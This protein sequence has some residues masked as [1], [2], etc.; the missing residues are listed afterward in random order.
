M[1]IS[2]SKALKVKNRIANEIKDLQNIVAQNNSYIT[3]NEQP[4]DIKESYN[5]LVELRV[6]IGELKIK[7]NTANAN[8]IHNMVEISEL[9]SHITFL[10]SIDVQSGQVKNSR[11]DGTM[12]DKKVVFTA[13]DM[14]LKI[15]ETQKKIDFIQDEIDHYNANT[16][17]EF[18]HK[19]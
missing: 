4:F 7:I 15:K 13:K 17:I 18:S 8:I 9:K 11:Y 14:R 10:R 19:E 1:N 3:G 5:E 6:K 2:L 12:I 16:I